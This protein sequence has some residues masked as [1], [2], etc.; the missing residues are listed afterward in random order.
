MLTVWCIQHIWGWKKHRGNKHTIIALGCLLLFD[1]L[2]PWLPR[3]QMEKD[4]ASQAATEE[5]EEAPEVTQIWFRKV[6]VWPCLIWCMCENHWCSTTF[7]KTIGWE[8][9]D[10]ARI[11]PRQLVLEKFCSRLLKRRTPVD[12]H[13]LHEHACL[14]LHTL[15]RSAMRPSTIFSN[16][17]LTS[18]PVPEFLWIVSWRG[19]LFNKA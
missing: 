15:V 13:I 4:E 7:D 2:G 1:L 10:D 3:T 6:V 14:R 17:T 12:V 18:E 19:S 11:K 5:T 8:R 9:D 16:V